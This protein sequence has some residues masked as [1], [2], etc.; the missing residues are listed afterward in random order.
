[1]V[2]RVYGAGLI[3]IDGFLVTL[4]CSVRGGPFSFDIVGLPDAAIKEAKDRV[5]CAAESSGV[6]FPQKRILVNLAPADRKKEGTAFDLPLLIALLLADG[7]LPEGSVGEEDCFIGELS[8]SGQVLPQVGVLSRALAAKEAGCRR[9]FVPIDNAEEAAVVEGL[10]VYGVPTLSSLLLH[11]LEKRALTPTVFDK[12]EC[13]RRQRER[14]IPSFA[15]IRGQVQARRAFEV[16]AAGE[17]NVLLI[18]PPGAGK[19]MLAKR[20]PSILPPLTFPEAVETTRIHSAAGTPFEGGLMAGRPFRAPHHTVSAAGLVGGGTNPRPGE[21]S[22]AN[23]GVLFLDELPEFAPSLLETLRQPLED[24]EITVTRANAKVTYP[25]HFMLIAAM[26]PC[27]C[28]YFGDRRIPCTC[29][30]EDARRYRSRI[31]GPLLDR[32]DIQIEL[33]PLCYEDIVRYKKAEPSSVVAERV[34][35]A[36]EFA[37]RRFIRAGDAPKSNA[38]MSD[39]EM[40]RH[41]VL[42]E[43]GEALLRQAFEKMNLTARGHARLLRVSRTVAD[44][45]ESERI[46]MKHI[47]EAIQYRNLDRKYWSR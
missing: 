38:R 1:M 12:E 30:P 14:V 11:L 36:R 46:E 25:T 33:P 37:A 2:K 7:G 13:F 26:N 4:E 29:R 28:G 18:G 35:A 45:A 47:A 22:L 44:L 21:I 3:G 32:L 9:L 8:L 19:T 40:R 27:R 24:G 42:D 16:A 5:R 6:R 31:S 15:E 34:Q 43:A 23:N 10:T 39:D 41:C 20:L 17:H